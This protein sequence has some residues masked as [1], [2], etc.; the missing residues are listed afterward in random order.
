MVQIPH[1]LIPL[2]VKAGI[3]T[4]SKSLQ[5]YR[6][7]YQ[8]TLSIRCSLKEIGFQDGLLSL[9]LYALFVLKNPKEYLLI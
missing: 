7:K 2:E 8:P 1:G 5:V 4:K 6:Q 9:P 3:N